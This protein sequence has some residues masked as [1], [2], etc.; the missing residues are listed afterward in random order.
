MKV[1]TWNSES[2]SLLTCER[3]GLTS[4]H[5]KAVQWRISYSEPLAGWNCEVM[6]SLIMAMVLFQH[7]L[8]RSRT[9]VN[10]RAHSTSGR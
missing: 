5:I 7:G 9:G 3:G 1:R 2:T 8:P 6:V 10:S 4:E